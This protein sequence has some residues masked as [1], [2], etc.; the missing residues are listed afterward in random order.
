VADDEGDGV[1]QYERVMGSETGPT[2]ED[3]DG[4]E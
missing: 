4:Q 1:R 2:E 3:N